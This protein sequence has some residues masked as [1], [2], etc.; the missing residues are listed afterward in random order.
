MVIHQGDI[1]W[2][3]LPD[4][5][6]SAPAGRRPVI[7]L[8]HD[9][10]NRT[11][12]ATAVVVAITSKLKYAELPGNVRLRK[13]EGGLPRASVVNVTQVATIDRDNLGPL[14]G[15]VSNARLAEVWDG[16]RLVCEPDTQTSGDHA[17]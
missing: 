12:I 14:L 10:F 15:K 6:G 8:Q 13:G 4:S 1:V 3:S 7:I 11:R 9:R 2:V 5:R 17:R 16:I